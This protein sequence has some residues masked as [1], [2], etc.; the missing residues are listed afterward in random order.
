MV[1]FVMSQA[2]PQVMIGRRSPVLPASVQ[3]SPAAVPV[4]AAI[5]DRHPD[6]RRKL[7]NQQRVAAGPD[8]A[9]RL[10]PLTV[11]RFTK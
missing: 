5:C 2:D 10:H 11:S 7:L 8:L 4:E 1:P 3:F 6:Q 9:G